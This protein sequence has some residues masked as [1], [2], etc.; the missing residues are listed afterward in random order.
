MEQLGLDLDG[1]RP[2]A[3]PSRRLHLH[4]TRQLQLSKCML[5]LCHPTPSDVCEPSPS[6]EVERRGVEGLPL[7]SWQL[8]AGGR[9]VTSDVWVTLRQSCF[10]AV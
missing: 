7:R 5:L 8:L 9:T 1:M 2:S 10:T 6:K 3:R 4:H